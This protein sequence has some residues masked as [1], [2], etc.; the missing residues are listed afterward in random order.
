MR[1]SG[2]HYPPHFPVQ[3]QRPAISAPQLVPHPHSHPQHSNP[4]CPFPRLV[5]VQT[6]RV[7]CSA[8]PPSHTAPRRTLP[9]ALLHHSTAIKR[10]PRPDAVIQSLDSDTKYNLD[11]THVTAIRWRG[12]DLGGGEGD[13]R[14]DVSVNDDGRPSSKI[15]FNRFTTISSSLESVGPGFPAVRRK[16]QV[17]DSIV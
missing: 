16:E 11:P 14:V 5:T 15:P 4:P 8:F 7:P 9:D 1:Y 17:N 6:T 12:G 13:A 10:S 2:S 3:A